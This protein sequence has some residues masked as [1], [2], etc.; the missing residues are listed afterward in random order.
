MN[1]ENFLFCGDGECAFF[2]EYDS[3]FD[4]FARELELSSSRLFFTFRQFGC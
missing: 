2:R 1:T 3:I 4:A